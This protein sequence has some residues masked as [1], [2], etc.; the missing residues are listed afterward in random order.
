MDEGLHKA[1][2]VTVLLHAW[3]AGQ[4]DAYSQLIDIVYPKLC[5]L[6]SRCMRVWKG[7]HTLNA[8]SLVHE[9]YLKILGTELPGG[10]ESTFS[11]FPRA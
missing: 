5:S 6:A 2:N 1:D 11:P 10:I 9:A 7:D 4:P 3:R 8:T